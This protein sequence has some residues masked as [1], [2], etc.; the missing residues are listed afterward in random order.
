MRLSWV[1]DR[2]VGLG[3]FWGMK[4]FIFNIAA[5]IMAVI[6]LSGCAAVGEKTASLVIVYG[7]AAILAL[8]LLVGYCLLVHKKEKWLLFLFS[9]VSVVN[10]G[11]YWLS[12]SSSVEGALMANRLAYLGSVFLPMSVMM[13]VLKVTKIEYKKWVPIFLFSLG[14]AVFLLAASG[15]IL[16]VYYK[17]V[18]IEK[19]GGITILNKV[20][21][22][23]HPVYLFYLLSYFGTM[24]G[25][26]SYAFH[27][28][29]LDSIVHS[30]ILAFAVF[31]NIGVWFIE[32]LVQIEFEILS[33][34]YIISELFLLGLYM[35]LQ[36]SERR[37]TLSKQV[38][39]EQLSQLIKENEAK[40]G[41]QPT[42]LLSDEFKAQY[43]MFV[44]GL[45]SLTQT[46]RTVY[47]YYVEGKSTK[48]ILSILDIKENTL[49]YHNK[50]VYGKLGVSSRKQ[51]VEMS[52]ILKILDKTNKNG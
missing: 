45:D 3:G 27:K 1:A 16:D 25:T 40:N 47:G 8:I 38:T 22:P 44:S 26:I 31:V 39:S 30:I 32:Q 14:V 35:L 43:D 49:K 10:F 2:I 46:E 41:E 15:G 24:I 23:L 33:I 5:M 28:K 17:Q 4:K 18:W 37:I 20:Y 6:S 51:L 21:G 36:E 34:S 12:V 9:S 52:K 29:K 42:I 7:A 50:N 13:I 11:Y 48:E 19:V